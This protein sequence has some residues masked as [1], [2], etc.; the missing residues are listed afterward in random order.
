MQNSDQNQA[1]NKNSEL[2]EDFLQYVDPQKVQSVLLK[3]LLVYNANKGSIFYSL[4]H[5]ETEDLMFLVKTLEQ[6]Q[7]P[8]LATVAA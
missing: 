4:K 6:L 2:I 7:P 5:E 1:T 8:Q 3:L